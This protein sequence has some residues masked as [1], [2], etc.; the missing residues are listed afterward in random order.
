MARTVFPSVTV[1]QLNTKASIVGAEESIQILGGDM[2]LGEA[3]RDRLSGEGAIIYALEVD[4]TTE[5]AAMVKARGFVRAKNLFEPHRVT[6]TSV[7]K[8]GDDGVLNTYHV[9][10][11]VAKEGFIPS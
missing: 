11:G 9:G 8:R 3:L 7:R 2:E 4:A 1:L 6:V 10:V 5:R